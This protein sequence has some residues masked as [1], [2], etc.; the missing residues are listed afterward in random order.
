MQD[1]SLLL[2]AS[3]NA[4]ISCAFGVPG[5]LHYTCMKTQLPARPNIGHTAQRCDEGGKSATVGGDLYQHPPRPLLYRTHTC[6]EI[7]SARGSTHA[8]PCGFTHSS[9]RWATQ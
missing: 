4:I 7:F 6:T 3:I 2:H 5:M 9:K 8:N 1:R